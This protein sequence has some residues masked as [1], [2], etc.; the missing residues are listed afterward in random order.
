VKLSNKGRY[1]VRAIFDIAFHSGGKATQI[2]DISRRQGIPP[3][4]LEQIFQDL[5]RAGLVTSKRGPRGGYALAVDADD[6]RLG[7][8]VRALEGPILLGSGK[9]TADGDETSRV[10]TETAFSELS[11]NIEAC[12]DAITIQDLCNRGDAHDVRRAPPR[13]YVYSI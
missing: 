4:F 12:F 6:I 5:K 7:D 11:D 8:I 2:K 1:G 9:D 3:R 13:R 10:V